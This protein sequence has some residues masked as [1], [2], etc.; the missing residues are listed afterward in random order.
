MVRDVMMFVVGFIGC[1]ALK[2]NGVLTHS[3][4][5]R[6]LNTNITTHVI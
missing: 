6:Q 3:R 1:I 4:K 2:K 5:H